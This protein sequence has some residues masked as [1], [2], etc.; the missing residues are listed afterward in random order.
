VALSFGPIRSEKKR[1][2]AAPILIIAGI[3]ISL[4]IAGLALNT[5]LSLL[6]HA[7]ERASMSG[8]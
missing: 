8:R 1:V 7:S 6:I 5:L 2:I 3:A 4:A